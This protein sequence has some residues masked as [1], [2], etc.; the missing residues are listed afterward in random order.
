ML[1]N[2]KK[3]LDKFIDLINMLFL[4]TSILQIASILPY[5]VNNLKIFLRSL[6]NYIKN[7]YKRFTDKIGGPGIVVE[8]DE[9]KFVNRKYNRGHHIEGVWVLGMVERTPERRIVLRHV[10]PGS[11]IYTDGWKGYENLKE[12]FIHATVNHSLHFVDPLTGVHTNTIEA[13]W[14][15]LKK[16]FARDGELKIKYGCH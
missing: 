8:I 10:H 11:V 14:A 12:K 9:S 7:H 3:G 15:P 4:N 6:N 13:N 2:Y 16:T 1:E 5:K